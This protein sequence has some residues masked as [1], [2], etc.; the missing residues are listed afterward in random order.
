MIFPSS[1]CCVRSC[2]HLGFIQERS[3]HFRSAICCKQLCISDLHCGLLH[4]LSIVE[5]VVAALGVPENRLARFE[6]VDGDDLPEVLVQR[7]DDG[8]LISGQFKVVD[9][10]VIQELGF[11]DALQ[12]QA[13][14]VGNFPMSSIL[15]QPHDISY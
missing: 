9:L 5:G 12:N 1:V 13:R 2:N 3:K 15:M 8:H 10:Q 14:F 4:G 11:D 7:V 6:L